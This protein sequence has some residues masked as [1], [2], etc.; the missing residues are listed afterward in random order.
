MNN[1][2]FTS[3]TMTANGKTFPVSYSIHASAKAVTVFV[4][5]GEDQKQAR[6][7]FDQ[8]H[9]DF[10]RVL[11]AAEAAAE[12]WKAKREGKTEERPEA[13]A[14]VVANDQ[15]KAAPEAVETVEAVRDERP[16]IIP[17][18]E[19]EPDRPTVEELNAGK[20]ARG[21]IPEKTFAGEAISGNGWS[22][23]FDT[24]LNRTRVIVSEK[25]KEIAV[26][27]IEAAGFYYSKVSGSWNKKLTHRAH[28]AALALADDLRTA[29]A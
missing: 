1:Y 7:R 6:I 25:L 10:A 23:V 29:L 13:V 2:E 28:R 17:E 20:A 19:A 9:P 14:E 12:A 5:M 3:E 11:V 26:P 16:E 24:G 8:T 4:D 21:P 18:T 27:I 15:P 22:I